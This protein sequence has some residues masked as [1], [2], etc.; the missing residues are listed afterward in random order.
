MRSCSWLLLRCTTLL[1]NSL[2]SPVTQHFSFPIS[3][4]LFYHIFALL[5]RILLILLLS[6][7]PL[8]LLFSI[9]CISIPNIRY[10][11]HTFS[12]QHSPDSPSFF[13]LQFSTRL[14][15]LTNEITTA[16]C[17]DKGCKDSAYY[18]DCHDIN[19]T[20]KCYTVYTG[21]HIRSHWLYHHHL[22]YNVHT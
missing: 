21:L 5:T 3:I 9:F 19:V 8:L 18:N 1:P 10:I 2:L 12:L 7:S 11:F 22:P 16:L 4:H 15:F 20:S 6:I 14:S 17:S 13:S